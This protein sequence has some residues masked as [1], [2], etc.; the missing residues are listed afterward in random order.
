VKNQEPEEAQEPQE[1]QEARDHVPI[2]IKKALGVG[3][4]AGVFLF[5]GVGE[6]FSQPPA[7]SPTE[8]FHA[9]EGRS[10]APVSL[11]WG[12]AGAGFGLLQGGLV[13]LLGVRAK[14]LPHANKRTAALALCMAVLAGVFSFVSAAS[15]ADLFGETLGLLIGLAVPVLALM[16]GVAL[17]GRLF[18]FHSLYEV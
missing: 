16:S 11:A 8:Q 6:F 18:G 5:C 17:G 14:P 10:P 2:P 15:L 1:P 3:V 13:W 7:L 4:M 9:P 12:F